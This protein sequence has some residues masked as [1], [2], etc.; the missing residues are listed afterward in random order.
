MIS[1]PEIVT[2]FSLSSYVVIAISIVIL[3]LVN[4]AIPGLGGLIG[5]GNLARAVR[6]RAE[7]MRFS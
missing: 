3:A 7:M 6:V 4:S 2:A 1:S 5:E